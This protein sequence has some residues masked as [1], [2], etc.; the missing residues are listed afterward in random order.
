MNS[1]LGAQQ[2]GDLEPSNLATVRLPL[3]ANWRV[4]LRDLYER[5]AQKLIFIDRGCAF[6]M[7]QLGLIDNLHFGAVIPVDIHGHG[8]ELSAN[9]KQALLFADSGA[10]TAH[11]V[12]A[13]IVHKNAIP[14]LMEAICED[15]KLRGKEPS[16]SELI[17]I[18]LASDIESKCCDVFP[19][20]PGKEITKHAFELRRAARSNDGFFSTLAVRPVSSKISDRAAKE[21]VSPNLV[22]SLSLALGISA[23][24][25]FA[26][27]G[28][29]ANLFG[30]LLMYLSL[31]FDCVDGEV[32]RLTGSSSRFGAWFDGF[33]D[34]IKEHLLIVGLALGAPWA[35]SGVWFSG[36][37]AII[38]ITMRHL[39][40]FA[41]VETVLADQKAGGN[42]EGNDIFNRP[43]LKSLDIRQ[44]ISRV[45]H[46][47]VSE[48]WFVLGCGVLLFDQRA[49]LWGY[50]GYVSVSLILVAIGWFIRTRRFVPKLSLPATTRLRQLLGYR[51]AASEPRSPMWWFSVPTSMAVEGLILL[52]FYIPSLA[53]ENS[54]W[55]ALIATVAVSWV[56]Y[57]DMYAET[58]DPGCMPIWRGNWYI[59]SLIWLSTIIFA[60]A[61]PEGSASWWLCGWSFV[62]MFNIFINA[63]RTALRLYERS[64]G[65]RVKGVA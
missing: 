15:V 27:G 49:A 28:P 4:T 9:A 2:T 8:Y 55:M 35:D 59:R 65:P 34:R 17:D 23:A 42:K 39:A 33:T 56:R 57:E 24:V 1:D 64:G 25:L 52:M 11:P 61:G 43:G 38:V 32:A 30:V 31:V 48:R 7:S 14:A 45:L 12:G 41:F 22:T 62:L 16:F 53:W 29:K 47:P 40:H 3:D 10:R 26:V 21:R 19:I 13:V 5:D 63:A 18:I 36:S 37:L 44:W 6:S 58:H 60:L 50:T 46:A 51:R 54:A 20:Q